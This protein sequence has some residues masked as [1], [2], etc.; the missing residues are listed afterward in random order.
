MTDAISDMAT[1]IGSPT[2]SNVFYSG[3]LGT[4]FLAQS[5]NNELSYKGLTTA[6]VTVNL[7]NGTAA[8]SQGATNT[9]TFG[10]GTG[11]VTVQGSTGN[12]TFV[13]GTSPVVLQG[14]GG[15][16]AIDLSQVQVG[17]TVNLQAGVISPGTGFGGV[18]YTPGCS[19]ATALCVTSVT[20]TP[21]ADTFIAGALSTANPV[22]ITGNGGND[23]LN[24]ADIAQSATVV[25]PITT[26]GVPAAGYVTSSTSPA[27]QAPP[28]ASGAGITFS[29]VSTLS[30]TAGG[31]D[32]VYAG[33]GTETLTESSTTAI[34]DFSADSNA[35]T[36]T[37]GVSITAN[38]VGGLFTGSV[39]SSVT[40]NVTDMFTG[41]R[42]FVG[43][44]GDGHVRPVRPEPCR[45]LRLL[46]QGRDQHPQPVR[47]PDRHHRGPVDSRVLPTGAPAARTT[48]AR[49]PT[50]ECSRT[51]SPAWAS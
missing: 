48:T 32:H 45:R 22:T 41:F 12:D 35:D 15:Q 51:R 27:G 13:I 40:L 31:G 50:G 34:L 49:H 24:L 3:L 47:G 33:T 37:A 26:L 19:S 25:M 44:P 29:G 36:G 7:K 16:D 21:Q 23:T 38:D 17:V 8:L 20:G 18:T 42:T 9:D 6:G 43:T 14:G 2:G 30:G 28:P 1:V 11:S 5:P 46:R 4:S 10:F 39:S